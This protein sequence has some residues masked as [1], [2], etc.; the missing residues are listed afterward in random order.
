MSGCD[1]WSNVMET[2]KV[3]PQYRAQPDSAKQLM[4]YISTA[5]SNGKRVRMTGSG[6]S[7]SD[8][9]ITGDALFTP[10]KLNKPL[11]LDRARLKTPPTTNWCG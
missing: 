4:S 5:S 11:T 8:V 9:A 3:T 2:E 1:E 6:H 10:E 7:A